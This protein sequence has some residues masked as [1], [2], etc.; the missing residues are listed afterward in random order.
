MNKYRD[1]PVRSALDVECIWVGTNFLK[2][3]V[4]V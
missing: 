2:K 4:S 1:Q 3:Q